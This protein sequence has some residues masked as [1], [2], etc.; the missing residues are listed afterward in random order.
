MA[1]S[2]EELKNLLMRVKE[3]SEKSSFKLN[4]QKTKIIACSLITSQQVDGETVVT[5]TDFIFLGSNITADSDCSHQTKRQLPLGRKTVTNIDSIIKKQRHYFANKGPSSQSNGFSSSHVRMWELDY[6][7]SWV[8]KNLCFWAVMLEKTLESPLDCKE[9]KPVN[10][11]ANQP[12]I[13]IGR[14]DAEAPIFWPS[15]RDIY[16][17]RDWGQEEKGMTEDEMA[18]WHHQLDGHEFP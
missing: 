15:D 13:F 1:E 9:I 17:G 12:W 3:E 4:I 11:K 5:V 10:P 16:A 14:T 7:E 18:E 6:K 8:L 2:E